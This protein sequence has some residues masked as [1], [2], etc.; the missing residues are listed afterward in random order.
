MK[1]KSSKQELDRR[2]A[3]VAHWMLSG[4]STS[5]IRA[6]VEKMWKVSSRQADNYIRKAYDRLKTDNEREFQQAK[7]FHLQA[8]M[9]AYRDLLEEEARLKRS[10]TISDY[11]RAVALAALKSKTAAFLQDMAKIEGLYIEKV[12]HSGEVEQKIVY[13]LPDGTEVTM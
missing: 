1:E 3:T 5:D 11:G 10:Q 9:N 6:N 12:E 7:M 13:R 2:V 4:H 8:R